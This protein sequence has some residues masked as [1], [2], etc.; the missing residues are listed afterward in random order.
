VLPDFSVCV[1]KYQQVATHRS[2]DH[3]AAYGIGGY[4]LE[5]WGHGLRW[6]GWPLSQGH[7]R[8][9]HPVVGGV[10]LLSRRAVFGRWVTV[11]A[12]TTRWCCL[13]FVAWRKDGVRADVLGGA[14]SLPIPSRGRDGGEVVR[15]CTACGEGRG[16]RSWLT[17][18]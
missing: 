14:R 4:D 13:V 5:L 1:N 7:H 15:S 9:S 11:L 6:L 18:P 10:V 3:L 12:V 16:K 17:L 2:L 8:G